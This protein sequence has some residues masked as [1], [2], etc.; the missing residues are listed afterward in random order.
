MVKDNLALLILLPPPLKGLRGHVDTSMFSL[1]Y[2]IYFGGVLRPQV[3]ILL[4]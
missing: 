4:P 1:F 3:H 2:L